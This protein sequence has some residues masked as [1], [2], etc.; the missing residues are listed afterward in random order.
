MSALL[1]IPFLLAL[2]FLFSGMEAGLLSLNR[3]RL[4]HMARQGD[5]PARRLE[6]LLLHPQRLMATVLLA[7]NFLNIA[8]LVLLAS[9]LV[10]RLG[11]AGYAAAFVVGLPLTLFVVEL[12]PKS[13]FRR[14]PH[15]LLAAFLPLLELSAAVAYPLLGVASRFGGWLLPKR[16]RATRNLF[17]ARE[18]FKFLTSEGERQGMLS[19]LERRMIHDVVD[20][21]HV[22]AG[23]VMVPL[24]RMVAV[25]ATLPVAEVLKIARER[26]IDRLPV[27][28]PAGEFV[29]LIHSFDALLAHS[30]Q[31][32]APAPVRRLLAVRPEEPAFALLRKLRAARLTLAGVVDEAGRP[33]GVV[34]EEDL[35]DRLV[36]RAAGGEG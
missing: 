12:F 27:L 29:G 36:R 15:R 21:S 6:R 3:V 20:F 9:A 4:S 8:A 28:G 23:D 16:V 18:H 26:E 13:M 1:W 35:I 31:P 32:D 19:G 5:R 14:F 10:D 7:T 22:R 34:A 24:D 11:P 30:E 25:P 2:S 17:A 33:L